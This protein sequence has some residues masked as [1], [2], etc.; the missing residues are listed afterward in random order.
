MPKSGKPS[1]VIGTSGSSENLLVVRSMVKCPGV[2]WPIANGF[3]YKNGPCRQGKVYQ[4][5]PRYC[6]KCRASHTTGAWVTCPTC[7]GENYVPE[8]TR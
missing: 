5:T 4:W 8:G 1:E 2:P 7:S 6:T 3:V